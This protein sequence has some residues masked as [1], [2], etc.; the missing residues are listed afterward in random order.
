MLG[1][2][3]DLAGP[4]EYTYRE[5]R[6]GRAGRQGAHPCPCPCGCFTPG[7]LAPPQLVEYVFEQ[8]RALKPEVANVSPGIAD[9]LGRAI[10]CLPNPLITRDFFRRM[11]A[12]RGGRQGGAW[13]ARGV[14]LPPSPLAQADVVLDPLAPTKRLSDLGIEATSLEMPAH[15]WLHRHRTGSHFL[16]LAEARRGVFS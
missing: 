8:M 1:Q 15:A 2:T 6:G 13:A 12:G 10:D 3:Y 7:P 5:V 14:N 4:D 11:Q 16:D 9:S